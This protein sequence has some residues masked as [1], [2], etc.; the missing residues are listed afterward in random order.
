MLIIYIQIF[1]VV[2]RVDFYSVAHIVNELETIQ[3]AFI[4]IGVKAQIVLPTYK[5]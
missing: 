2:Y 1:Q 5:G 3:K 4:G